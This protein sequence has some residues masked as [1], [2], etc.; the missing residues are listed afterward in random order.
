MAGRTISAG[1]VG[2]I[3]LAVG[4]SPLTITATGGVS[5]T[6]AAALT[7]AG[8]VDWV[9]G[10]AGT[11]AAGGTG[12]ASVGIQM[13]AGTA[14]S[15]G[16][17]I[18]NELIGVISGG[19]FGIYSAKS[20]TLSNAGTIAGTGAASGVGVMFGGGSVTNLGTA[21]AITGATRGVVLNGAGTVTNAGSIGGTGTGG[22]GVL[23][24]AGGGFDN[25]AGGR[26]TGGYVGAAAIG[27]VA[28]LISNAGTLS[29]GTFGV[30]V[31][32]S[33]ADFS[34]TSTGVITGGVAG[35]VV[36]GG[37]SVGNAGSVSGRF[38]I[39]AITGVAT[40]TNSGSVKST[41]KFTQ[42]QDPE[43][44]GAGI[45]VQAGGTI[46]NAA[47]G[48]ISAF[49][50]G[51]QVGSFNGTNANGGAVLNAGVITANDPN[52][53]GAAVWFKGNGTISNAATGSIGGGPFGIV[54]YDSVTIVNR[55]AISGTNFA[56]T[57]SIAGTN[58]RIIV[59]PGASFAGT[60]LGDKAGV[61]VPTGVLELA[62]G[63]ASGTIT[64]F[65]TK[66][67]SFG[68]VE[69]NA[70]ATWS[71]AGTVSSGQTLALGGAGAQVTLANPGS[72]AGVITGFNSST[73]LVL[74]GVADVTGTSL[75]AGNVL[76]VT[77][78]GGGTIALRFDPAQVFPPGAFGFAGGTG[79]TSLSAP[80][81]ALGTRIATTTGDVPVEALAA[82]MR[83]LRAGGGMAEVAWLG[84]RR[85]DCTRHPR[86]DEVWPVRIQAGAFS[87]GVPA[88][89]LLLSPD[90][91]VFV[92]GVLIPVRHLMNGR[93]IRQER[94]DSITYFHVELAAHDV[95]LAEGL[96]C[97]SYLDTG[98]RGAFANGGGAV[99]LH[100]DFARRQWAAASCAPLVEGGA[101]LAAA[102]TRLL[103]RAGAFGHRRSFDPALAVLAD[104]RTLP[105][106]AQGRRRSVVLPAG[107]GA[108]AIV[109]RQFVPAE[110][111]P[112]G[113][114][115]RRLGVGVARIA[116]DGVRLG[117]DDPRLGG[118]WHPP[119]GAW[120][121]SD[122]HGWLHARGA[123]VLSFEVAM[124]GQYWDAPGAG[125]KRAS[126][127]MK[128]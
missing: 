66:Y 104:G 6:D 76:T 50:I 118:G 120:R 69:V 57:T 59:Y 49:W 7:T 75:D 65:G 116:L 15:A 70:G 115:T 19:R 124:V 21:A 55:G 83:V 101:A 40:V 68:R 85:V 127:G 78:S 90:H 98:N 128:N 71:L 58:N 67:L 45:Q 126:G 64:G 11:I 28:A 60:V 91:A 121:W 27:K 1:Y 12:A 72:V 102:R 105:M 95:I 14:G 125:G 86:P 9:I 94:A 52:V 93:T 92:G 5:S 63:A 82:G 33:L 110:V 122:G 44:V 106:T 88:R 18:T 123:G 113:E 96:A 54:S 47:G 22:Y 97:E 74:G 30:G 3:G 80:C 24:K 107:G 117:L 109:S 46:V 34:N 41:G 77:R 87:R 61:A 114:D 62:A 13:N 100:A 37:G 111:E 2:G 32:N 56:V 119:E 79:G 25:Q 48:T 39:Q 108:V 81:F 112:A 23:L 103:V 16:G 38:G 17:T 31:A 42:G 89:D 36:L 20:V 4:D 10:N 84:H 29:G 99:M 43:T 51:A 73:H 26:V 35:V 8:T 53:S